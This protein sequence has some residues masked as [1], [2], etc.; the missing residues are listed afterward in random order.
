[1]PRHCSMC[2]APLRPGKH[3]KSGRCGACSRSAAGQMLKRRA[4]RK[5][6]AGRPERLMQRVVDRPLGH[7]W[8]PVTRDTEPGCYVTHCRACSG[9]LAYD[10]SESPKPYGPKGKC[11]GRVVAQPAIRRDPM[12]MER[13]ST[14]RTE[15]AMPNDL[16]PIHKDA[17]GW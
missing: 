14:P 5:R 1:V 8:A 13:S 3:N 7:D 9:V 10:A 11:P 4:L 2:A 16:E 17:W 12:K 6:M 15:E